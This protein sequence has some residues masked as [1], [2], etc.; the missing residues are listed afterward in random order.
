MRNSLISACLCALVIAPSALAEK[1][2]SLAA[3]RPS[4]GDERRIALVIG[5]SAYKSSPLRNPVNDARA[6][7]RAFSE[8]GF[9]VSL[10]EDATLAGMRRA[11]REFGSEIAS[12]G[13]GVFYYAGHGIQLRGKNYLIPV[14][15]DIQAED[16][17]ED[18]AVDAN[19]IIAKM[20]SAR[21][22]LNI[23]ILDACRN[24]PFARTFRSV[25]QGLAQMD[26]P[27]G[28][29]VAFATAPGSVAADGTGDHGIYTKHLLEAIRQPGLPIEQL[30]KQVRIG[31]T[32]E[33][34]DK[35]TPWE[36]S[37]LKG[38]FY[39]TPRDPTKLNEERD[40]AQQAAMKLALKDAE[41][42]AAKEREELRREATAER[43]AF[44]LRAAEERAALE[45]KVHA[46]VERL[47]AAQRDTQ[48]AQR[49]MNERRRAELQ[50]QRRESGETS[51][52]ASVPQADPAPP[53]SPSGDP[54]AVGDST[55]SA[56]P[57]KSDGMAPPDRP[58]AATQP[59]QVAI[60][61]PVPTPAAVATRGL[62][63]VG[64]WWTYRVTELEREWRRRVQDVIEVRGV[65][66]AEILAGASRGLI[67][68]SA[69]V[70]TTGPYVIGST[71]GAIIFSPHIG[72]FQ[73]LRSGE[74]WKDVKFTNVA[75][76]ASEFACRISGEV[77]G[78]ERVTV[79]AG[80]FE[81]TKIELEL[82]W[83]T[84]GDRSGWGKRRYTFWY[85]DAA[86]RVVKISGRDHEGVKSYEPDVDVE[87]IAFELK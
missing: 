53:V 61:S 66:S 84:I 76:C 22:S 21:N 31:V 81:A 38:D 55:A 24:N 17:V 50:E 43:A 65:T 72:L 16:E 19:F 45:K 13:V 49:L 62:P 52:A 48:E 30:F 79:P 1:V 47:L 9:Q 83:E 26:A 37:S 82:M 20:D 69:W 23:V 54:M 27:S 5:N 74:R 70:H 86:K 15:A 73:E 2:Q 35:Q 32:R 59:V 18:Q 34:R 78:K 67:E 36:S 6:I 12:G 51:L 60:V 29:L 8:S 10:V 42:R 63:K 39:F 46:L 87:L 77:K 28:T 40:G 4:P 25:S 11:A 3:A 44:E 64:D 71:Q 85:A 75:F 41:A 68:P 7:A 80:D 58:S 14:N 56:S 33:T 57:A